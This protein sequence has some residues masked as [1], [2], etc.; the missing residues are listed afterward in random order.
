MK[1]EIICFDIDNV[2]CKTEQ[3]FYKKSKPN[4][5][6]ISFINKLY[7]NNFYIKLFTARFMGQCRGNKKKVRN[8]AY[9][10]TK[11]Q[12]QDWGLKYH[13]LILFKPS[14]DYI[15][16]DKAIGFTSNWMKI[17]DKKLKKKIEI[18]K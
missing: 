16:D 18:E 15:I 17:L 5:K 8:K 13:E 2:I 10:L 6:V 14:Y 4:K 9:K 3:N 1:K 12:L 11:K 7:K